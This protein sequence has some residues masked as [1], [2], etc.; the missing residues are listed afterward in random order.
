MSNVY[1]RVISEHQAP[2]D[3][4]W[5]GDW[6]RLVSLSETLGVKIERRMSAPDRLVALGAVAEGVT[7]HRRER[8]T[9]RTAVAKA[10]D[11]ARKKEAGLVEVVCW[12]P[13]RSVEKLKVYAT[14]LQDEIPGL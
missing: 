5:C 7:L 10:R 1:V 9:S 6:Y 4:F 14:A 2:D 8:S 11:R 13:K 12:V 3:Y